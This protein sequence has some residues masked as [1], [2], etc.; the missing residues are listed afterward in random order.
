MHG[1]TIHLKAKNDVSPYPLHLRAEKRD[2][3]QPCLQ[4]PCRW[5]LH[6]YES[7]LS[8]SCTSIFFE[9][10]INK[11]SFLNEPT[12]STELFPLRMMHPV[13]V[14]VTS[15]AN[16]EPTKPRPK[17]QTHSSTE[18]Y[19]AVQS[20]TIFVHLGKLFLSPTQIKVL[21]VCPDT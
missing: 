6:V 4:R 2:H 18:Q 15:R 9:G 16:V 1:R 8:I 10:L 11:P 14:L 17:L 5:A 19:R 12:V 7:T 3:L 20:S 13:V 21:I